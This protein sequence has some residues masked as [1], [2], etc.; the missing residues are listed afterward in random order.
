MNKKLFIGIPMAGNAPLGF[1]AS[2]VRYAQVA[3]KGTVI[4][5]DTSGGVGMA[6]NNL[7]A[8]FLAGDCTHLLFIDSDIIFEPA[9]VERLMAHDL[10][11]VG[12]LYPLKSEGEFQLC[13]NGFNDRET[14]IAANGLQQVRYIGTGFMLIARHV[15]EN[16]IDADRAEIEYQKDEPPHATQWDLWRMG[17]RFT[18]DPRRRFLTEDW[19]FCQRAGERGFTV[20]ADTTICLRHIGTAI[21]PLPHQRGDAQLSTQ[22]PIN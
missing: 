14:P 17:V 22:T 7:T 2:L 3:P 20:W 12:G 15:I 18:A 21:W 6:R 11:I 5:F 10:P 4:A 8:K 16:L 13:G 19:F 9:Q 1:I